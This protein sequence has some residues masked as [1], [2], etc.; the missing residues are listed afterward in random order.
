MTTRRANLGGRLTKIDVFGNC[1]AT[2]PY[3][4]R[5]VDGI[6]R[7]GAALRKYQKTLLDVARF[8]RTLATVPGA[9]G[10]QAND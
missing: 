6:R 4:F 10:E 3:L 9:R 5:A 2:H 8:E 7:G 1:V